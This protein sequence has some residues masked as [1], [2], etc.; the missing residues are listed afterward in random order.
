MTMQKTFVNL[1]L[2]NRQVQR[3]DGTDGNQSSASCIHERHGDHGSVKTQPVVGDNGTDYRERHHKHFVRV[4]QRGGH[5]R[6]EAQLSMEE[7]RH[8]C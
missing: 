1:K 2:L 6:V 3:L 5:G 4:E 7:Q 8:C